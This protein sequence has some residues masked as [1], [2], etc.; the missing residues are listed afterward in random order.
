VAFPYI[1]LFKNFIES[2]NHDSVSYTFSFSNP[3]SLGVWRN[4]STYS[5]LYY[6]D[7]D[8]VHDRMFAIKE[9]PFFFWLHKEHPFE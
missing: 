5:I 7:D 1:R 6:N 2:S 8:N 9:H 4:F 3:H